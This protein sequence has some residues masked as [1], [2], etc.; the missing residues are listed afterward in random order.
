[1]L[2]GYFVNTKTKTAGMKLSVMTYRA[3]SERLNL[4]RQSS[5]GTNTISQTR[6][7]SSLD[8]WLMSSSAQNR[9]AALYRQAYSDKHSSPPLPRRAR[10]VSFDLS[11]DEDDDDED[12]YFDDDADDEVSMLIGLVYNYTMHCHELRV[13]D[14]R[15]KRKIVIL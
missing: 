6:R 13:K 8:S 14:N 9:H 4:L 15:A 5:Y 3:S 10:V 11:D 2:S 12:D 7:G 1:M